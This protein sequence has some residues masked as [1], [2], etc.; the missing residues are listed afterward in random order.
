MIV[1]W[2]K[3]SSGRSLLKSSIIVLAYLLMPM[4]AVS[5]A[6]LD[7]LKKKVNY[8]PSYCKAVRAETTWLEKSQGLSFSQISHG[9]TE[10]ALDL[11]QVC[12]TLPL[13]HTKEMTDLAI[14]AI[15]ESPQ[16]GLA[17]AF[18]LSGSGCT[19]ECSELAAGL[20]NASSNKSSKDVDKEAVKQES[21][22]YLRKAKYPAFS[23]VL[24]DI[25]IIELG[26]QKGI[27]KLKDLDQRQLEKLKDDSRKASSEYV[28]KTSA[29]PSEADETTV[30]AAL[31]KTL[32]FYIEEIKKAQGYANELRSIVDKLK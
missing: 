7:G 29:P 10:R 12:R 1:H 9:K 28:T 17:A 21:L 30:Q 24:W 23:N 15:K 31:K 20:I 14:G 26:I 5:A 19:R 27:W 25:E 6:A 16:E 8:L 3:A 22:R 11:L 2:L 18:A 32:P 13:P 4:Q